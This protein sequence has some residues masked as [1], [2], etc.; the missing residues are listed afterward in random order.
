M[1]ASVNI[2]C[3]T[4]NT[5]DSRSSANKNARATDRLL[6]VSS[7]RQGSRCRVQHSATPLFDT[8]AITRHQAPP[9]QTR[10]PEAEDAERNRA[11]RQVPCS[12][13]FRG[14]QRV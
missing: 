11:P 9:S 3:P 6:I 13:F 8:H 1:A 12:E 2:G 14:R 7:R 5:N 4:P 10:S